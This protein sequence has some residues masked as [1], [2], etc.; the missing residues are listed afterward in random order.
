MLGHTPLPRLQDLRRTKVASRPSRQSWLGCFSSHVFFS[1]SFSGASAPTLTCRQRC[2]IFPSKHYVSSLSPN[3]RLARSSQFHLYLRTG[4]RLKRGRCCSSSS[5][6]LPSVTAAPRAQ[7][8]TARHE[9][10]TW[11]VMH[12][13]LCD[14]STSSTGLAV[15]RCYGVR[16]ILLQ[17]YCTARRAHAAHDRGV[18]LHVVKLPCWRWACVVG[19]YEVWESARVGAQ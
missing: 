19:L 12:P 15:N 13:T 3:P 7:L 17:A 14:R 5:F 18:L 9:L 10:H 4:I 16:P 8:I 1:D 11:H 2:C 6:G